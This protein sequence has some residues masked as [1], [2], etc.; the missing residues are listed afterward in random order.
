MSVVVDTSIWIDFFAGHTIAPLEEALSHGIVVLPPIV[1][2]ELISG[3]HKAR[4]RALI[5]GLA[6]ELSVHPTPIDH[7]IRVGELRCRL[8]ARGMSISTPDAHVAQCAL[9]EE[10]PLLSRDA[11][12]K[13]ISPICGLTITE[14]KA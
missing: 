13:K 6:R 10:A 8:Q 14:T 4:D 5:I 11:I 2:A 7:W 9:D 3:A 1:L 12:F